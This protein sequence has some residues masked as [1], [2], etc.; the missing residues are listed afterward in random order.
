M[1]GKLGKPGLVILSNTSDVESCV[2]MNAIAYHSIPS[3]AASMYLWLRCTKTKSSYQSVSSTSF[4]MI[5]QA[6]GKEADLR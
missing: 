5:M 3:S 2:G 1:K 6:K 4:S